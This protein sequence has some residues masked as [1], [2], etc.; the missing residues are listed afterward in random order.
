METIIMASRWSLYVDGSAFDNGEGG[1]R[2]L[3]PTY[4]DLFDRLGEQ[5]KQDDP[6][7]KAR[8]LK[9]YVDDIQAYLDSGHNV[10]L[11]YPIP[12]AGWNV[13]ELV[14]KSAMSGIQNLEFSTSY[15]RYQ[16]RNAVVIAAFDAISHPNLFRVRPADSFCNSFVRN[17]CINSLSAEK[18]FYFDDDHPSDSGA[19]LVIPAILKAVETIEARKTGAALVKR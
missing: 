10:V 16:Q 19:Q 5:A 11:V 12:E 17:R 9:Q 18:V 2:P 7:R 15:N 1:I 6:Q 14:A 4:V 3:Q 13:P 8:V